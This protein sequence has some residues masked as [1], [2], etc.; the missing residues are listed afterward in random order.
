MSQT[1]SNNPA[2]QAAGALEIGESAC[3]AQPPS[4][5]EEISSQG[6]G[7]PGVLASKGQNQVCPVSPLAILLRGLCLEGIL[8]VTV[9]EHSLDK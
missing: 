5:S 3:P 6:S 1:D 4:C 8:Q 9:A 7:S 2:F